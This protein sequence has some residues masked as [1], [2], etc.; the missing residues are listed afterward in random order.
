MMKRRTTG[1]ASGAFCGMC[2]D[3]HAVRQ[4]GTAADRPVAAVA[5]ACTWRSA[6]SRDHDPRL[7]A[8]AVPGVAA[9]S[10]AGIADTPL[11][12][13][14]GLIGGLWIVIGSVLFFGLPSWR[15]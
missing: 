5:P 2:R 8:G 1:T 12:A 10:T 3:P 6:A 4:P 13:V 7:R 14:P 15:P 11:T 9:F